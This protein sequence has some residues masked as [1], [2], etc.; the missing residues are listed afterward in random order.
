MILVENVY[1]PVLEIFGKHRSKSNAVRIQADRQYHL[2]VGIKLIIFV[3]TF[4]HQKNGVCVDA[5]YETSLMGI[6]LTTMP[7]FP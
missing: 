7:I 3:D 1:S 4:V 6:H 5:E 2:H